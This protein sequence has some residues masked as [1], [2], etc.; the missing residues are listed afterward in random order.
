MQWSWDQ[1]QNRI[2][3]ESG[4]PVFKIE[5]NIGQFA[6]HE[7]QLL[8][9]NQDGYFN[10]MSRG[11]TV[12]LQYSGY[13]LPEML[14]TKVVAEEHTIQVDL[15]G[16]VG[17]RLQQFKCGQRLPGKFSDDN[18]HLDF[19][20][21]TIGDLT[22]EQLFNAMHSEPADFTSYQKPFR[23]Y[24]GTVLID[25]L[26]RSDLEF[27]GRS[28]NYPPFSP[29]NTGGSHN[30]YFKNFR[31]KMVYLPAP[32]DIDG[33]VYDQGIYIVSAPD[34]IAVGQPDW[35]HMNGSQFVQYQPNAEVAEY[36][37]D[38]DFEETIRESGQQGFR[39]RRVWEK[40]DGD[41]TYTYRVGY[42]STPTQGLSEAVIHWSYT[43]SKTLFTYSNPS[44]SDIFYDLANYGLSVFYTSQFRYII[45]Q[46]RKGSDV[47]SWVHN[48]HHVKAGESLEYDVL[49]EL[50]FKGCKPSYARALE[51]KAISDTPVET[52]TGDLFF[53]NGLFPLGKRLYMDGRDYGLV[54]QFQ[55][56]LNAPDNQARVVTRKIGEIG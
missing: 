4:N 23:K 8:L 31:S 45:I 50:T 29:D 46:P 9:M 36:F 38:I 49:G 52:W 3:R 26:D 54:I 33:L 41:Y 34:P 48:G 22:F 15:A 5:D 20:G 19:D 39:T 18:Y 12:Q 51:L 56:V 25:T 21:D 7:G 37:T 55:P 30:S 32:V 28:Q 53:V 2:D 27:Y 47:E 17:H 44:A 42:Y 10:G 13:D 40:E 14:V 6:N 43:A 35:E 24:S 1:I 16:H 11:D